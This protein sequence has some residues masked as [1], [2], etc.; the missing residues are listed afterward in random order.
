MDVH[1]QEYY[2]A[3]VTRNA[4]VNV[5]VFYNTNC[6]RIGSDHVGQ[7]A[8]LEETFNSTWF[9][10]STPEQ[11]IVTNWFP[12]IAST[13]TAKSL[14]ENNQLVLLSKPR[15]CHCCKDNEINYVGFGC[16]K[17]HLTSS[18]SEHLGV[19]EQRSGATI[20]DENI[21]HLITSRFPSRHPSQPL[22]LD[23]E[24][25]INF[26]NHVQQVRTRSNSFEA[27]QD[28]T[29]VQNSILQV[30]SDK[31]AMTD[32]Q[33]TDR[34]NRHVVITKDQRTDKCS[35]N[36]LQSDGEA[37]ARYGVL[38]VGNFFHCTLGL[39]YNIDLYIEYSNPCHSSALVIEQHIAEHMTYAR[40]WWD[41]NVDLLI[42][43]SDNHIHKRIVLEAMAK[44]YCTHPSIDYERMRVYWSVI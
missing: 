16:M 7:N 28:D 22:Q 36:S 4:D 2:N 34:T 5:E 9:K 1:H 18:T 10:N 42:S 26:Q 30:L 6:G 41:G 24:H 35:R 29:N 39:A 40:L 25:P 13:L 12:H 21:E 15:P 3:Q 14:V 32:G 43:M 17:D 33:Q 31:T 11:V 38:S 23:M 19:Q 27:L 44:L 37:F 8:S 20:S